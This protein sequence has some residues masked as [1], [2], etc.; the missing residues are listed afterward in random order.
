MGAVQLIKGRE[1]VPVISCPDGILLARTFISGADVFILSDPDIANNMGLA[2]GQNALL[3]ARVF[4]FVRDAANTKGPPVFIEP[5][6]GSAGAASGLFRALFEMPLLITTILTLLTL[7][8]AVLPACQRFGAPPLDAMDFAYGKSK[9]I[10]NSA[11]L[12]ERSG[13]TSEAAQSYVEMSL[14]AA[15]KLTRA[16]ERLGKS[17]LLDWLEQASQARGLKLS[18]KDL[19]ARAARLQNSPSDIEALRLAKDARLWKMELEHG[20]DRHREH[21]Q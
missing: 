17:S 20:S 19:A 21:R 15:G 3:M 9:L 14:R 12:V 16:P 7:L 4:E 5:M 8:L 10:D 1:L 13:R 2:R 11:R 6:G 18:P